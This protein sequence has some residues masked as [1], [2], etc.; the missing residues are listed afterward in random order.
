M[1][2]SYVATVQYDLPEARFLRAEVKP[3]CDTDLPFEID[4][5]H[6]ELWYKDDSGNDILEA[7]GECEIKKTKEKYEG[8]IRLLS[9]EISRLSKN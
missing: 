5:A 2:V 6:W 7:S 3:K 8:N 9:T 4:E 1:S